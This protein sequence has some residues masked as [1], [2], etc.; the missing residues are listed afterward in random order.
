[1]KKGADVLEIRMV[2]ALRNSFLFYFENT[3]LNIIMI[4]V[5]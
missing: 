3:C 2:L 1:M 5:Y 4:T